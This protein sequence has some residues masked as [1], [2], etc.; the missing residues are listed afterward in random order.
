MHAIIPCAGYG[1][2]MGMLPHESK[3]MMLN[4]DTGFRLIDR[5][6]NLCRDLDI[7]PI[8]VSRKG[9]YDL[10]DHISA[11]SDVD[12]VV[13]EDGESKD[14]HES[15]LKAKEYWHTN[16]I[17]LFPDTEAHNEIEA[18]EHIR[19][20]LDI[21]PIKLSLGVFSV[22]NPRKW[23]IFKPGGFILDKC[24]AIPI[25]TYLAIGMIGFN[26]DVGDEF[27]SCLKLN[28]V[29]QG[30]NIYASKQFVSF[31]QFYKLENFR[32]LTREPT[33]KLIK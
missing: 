2:R 20:T 31:L 22:D 4:L 12:L 17:V 18:M 3:E 27:F 8:V 5:T 19:F 10:N 24:K 30:Y 21:D 23:L 13:L 16:N 7:R 15:I 25:N 26:Y 1:T 6:I 28:G 9:K 32:D 14:W 11:M 33:D 29:Y